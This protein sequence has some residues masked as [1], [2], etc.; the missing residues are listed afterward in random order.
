M[1]SCKTAVTPLLSHWSYC[2]LPLSHWPDDFEQY[3][4]HFAVCSVT[5]TRRFACML[6]SSL[7]VGRTSTWS[8]PSRHVSSQTASNTHLPRATGATRR[9]P[10]R[11][12][13]VCRRCWTDSH[14][15][16]RCPICDVSTLQWVVTESWLGRDSCTIHYGAWSALPRHQR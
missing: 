12:V 15:L 2:I 5:W 14:L 10:I 3:N 11:L 4:F 9:R 8:W 1:A 6:R 16:L 13:L 7:T